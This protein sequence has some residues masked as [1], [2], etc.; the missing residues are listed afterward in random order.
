[1]VCYET[2]TGDEGIRFDRETSRIC[3]RFPSLR[4]LDGSY[5]IDVALRGVDG[6]MLDQRNGAASFEVD[7]S[8]F[9]YGIYR[10]DHEW[11]TR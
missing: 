11:E 10:P 6:Q 7:A 9:G 5:V 4:L 3:C 8:G 1:M 2:R